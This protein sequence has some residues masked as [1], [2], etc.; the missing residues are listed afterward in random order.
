M[1]LNQIIRLKPYLN[2]FSEMTTAARLFRDY[3]KQYEMIKKQSI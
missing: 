1:L 2:Y 3:E